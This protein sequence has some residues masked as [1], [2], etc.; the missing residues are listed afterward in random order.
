L[1]KTGL[2]LTIKKIAIVDCSKIDANSAFFIGFC[3][4]DADFGTIAR[5]QEPSSRHKKTRRSGFLHQ[6]RKRFISASE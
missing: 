2:N 3:T 1:H 5:L 6:S 4:I